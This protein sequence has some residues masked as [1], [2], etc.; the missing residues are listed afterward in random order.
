MNNTLT[1]AS[2]TNTSSSTT[3]HLPSRTEEIAICSALV[4]EAV[5]IAG[6]NSLTIFFFVLE[7]KLRKKSLLLVINMA[8]ADVMLG[9]VLLPLYIYLRIGFWPPLW[10]KGVLEPLEVFFLWIDLIFL[11]ASLISAVFISCERLYA[12]YWPLKHL[13]LS[14]R[15]YAI[16]ITLIWTLA[17]IVSAFFKLV[18]DFLPTKTGVYLMT[19]LISIFLLV[20]CCCN[21]GIWWKFQQRNNAP[22]NAIHQQNR[23]RQA[24]RLTK[25]LLAV[26]AAAV[27]SWLP[28][29]IIL[30]MTA[31]H[32][33]SVPIII[34]HCFYIVTYSSS[35]VNPIIYALKIPEFRQLLVTLCSRRRAVD[36][37]DRK[38][39]DEQDT[40]TIDFIEQRTFPMILVTQSG[41]LNTSRRTLNCGLPFPTHN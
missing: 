39:K 21:I 7:K 3:M 1:I 26:S 37:M 6:G 31:A 32:M 28:H 19:I 30:N 29:A 11:Q 20:L 36:R 5:L 8:F 9:A 23:A 10:R 17:F 4:I 15:A 35:F 38:G 22:R 24:R 27:F 18:R 14:T 2:F 41:T 40:G 33:V 25:T 34:F 13:T 16:V 12:V